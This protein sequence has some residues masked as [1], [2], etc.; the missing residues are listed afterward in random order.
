MTT[1]MDV[2]SIYDNTPG[3]KCLH[4][5][6][7]KKPNGGEYSKRADGFNYWS[8]C[9]DKMIAFLNKHCEGTYTSRPTE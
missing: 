9:P 6:E 2:Q 7:G 1:P 4:W 3:V 8:D 5:I